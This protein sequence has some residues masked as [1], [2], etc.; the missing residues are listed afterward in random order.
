MTKTDVTWTNTKADSSGGLLCR[1]EKWETRQLA[2]QCPQMANGSWRVEGIE[3]MY[4]PSGTSSH[5]QSEQTIS[6]LYRMLKGFNSIHPQ[7]NH[8]VHSGNSFYV[9]DYI[10]V[11]H[12]WS[13]HYIFFSHKA[14]STILI[15]SLSDSYVQ[16]NETVTE[17]GGS[18]PHHT[19][20]QWHDC[21]L[22]NFILFFY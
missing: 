22:L 9:T 6:I 18:S 17:F 1:R 3:G 15:F 8:S 11:L 19:T 2:S 20:S 4:S 21:S 7:K 16:Q 5:S 10:N 14:L 12:S 13:A